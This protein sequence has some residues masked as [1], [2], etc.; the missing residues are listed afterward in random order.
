MK[1]GING[2][3]LGPNKT[4]VGRYLYNLLKV[5]SSNQHGHE[6]IVYYSNEQLQPEDRALAE[7]GHSVIFRHLS[8][9]FRTNSFHLWYNFSLPRTI[10]SD[11]IDF[12]FSPD[13]FLP[14]LRKSIHRSLTVHDVSYLSHPEWFP[15]MY[16]IYGQLYSKRPA[17]TADIVFTVSQFSK[18]EILKNIE[19]PEQRVVVTSEAADTTFRSSGV[20]GALSNFGFKKAYFLFVGKIF[21]RRHVDAALHAFTRYLASSRD[22]TTQFVIRGNNETRPRIDILGIAKKINADFNRDAVI[23]PGYI[24]DEE[25]VTLYQQATGFFYLS[26]YEGFGLPVLEALACGVPTVTVR[27][28]SITEV[29]GE[30]G[31]Y[32]EPTDIEGLKYIMNRL[33]TD[34][35]WV[36]SVR[37]RSIQQA[38]RFSW[39]KTATETLLAIEKVYNK[40]LIH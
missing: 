37:N 36:T 2:R 22:T 24:S 26:S 40:Q 27:G 14:P 32:V 25:L 5:W 33:I 31:I 1:I 20:Q 12:F 10:I 3:Y 21:N 23:F 8:R 38:Q 35:A 4:G 15:F 28:S 34:P 17:R 16:R 19:I 13:Y 7:R 30:A 9:P 6:F 11:G 39:Q 18:Q 29:A